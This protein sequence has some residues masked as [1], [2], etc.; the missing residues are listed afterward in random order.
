MQNQ[1][2]VLDSPLYAFPYYHA[3]EVCH[4]CCES[5]RH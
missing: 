4:F 3:E 1:P 5:L 2:S